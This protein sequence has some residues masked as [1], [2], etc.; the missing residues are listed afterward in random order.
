M[1]TT[2][3]TPVLLSAVLLTLA[4]GGAPVEDQEQFFLRG[5]GCGATEDPYLSTES[6]EDGLDGCGGIGGL[7][8]NEIFNAAGL[9][10][11]TDFTTRDGVPVVVDA[12]RN[13]TGQVQAEQWA[14]GTVS[15]GQVVVELEISGIQEGG[16]TSV[17]LGTFTDEVIVTPLDGDG[18]VFEF[19]LD[20]PDHISTTPFKQ[21]TVNVVVRGVN[22]NNSNLGLSGDSF[23]TLPTLVEEEV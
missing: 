5:D 16:F 17:T 7:P 2:L 4:A 19:D 3:V 8:F 18:I 1:R 20:I 10:V 14:G 12:T 9:D 6:G 11:S 23:I 21:L 13:L 15:A 22:Q